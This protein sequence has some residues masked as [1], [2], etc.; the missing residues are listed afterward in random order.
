MVAFFN[1]SPDEI[2]SFVVFLAPIFVIICLLIFRQRLKQSQAAA[3]VKRFDSFTDEIDDLR[4][5]IAN[6][7]FE[8]AALKT[9]VNELAAKLENRG[10]TDIT[11]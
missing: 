6:Q 5:Q 10:S 4:E 3:T 9:Q 8:I 1:V 11:R 2:I 7:R